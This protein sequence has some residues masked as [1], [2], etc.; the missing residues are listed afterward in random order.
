MYSI[1]IPLYNGVE[2]LKE[3]VNSVKEQTYQEW[4]II[5]GI[6]GHS[7]E[8]DVMKHALTFQN[9]KIRVKHYKTK[10]KP[11]TLNEMIKDTRYDNICILDVDD[12]WLPNKL[13]IQKDYID[14]YDVIGTHCKYFGD[15]DIVPPL[16]SGEIYKS[17][18]L[19]V[20]NI[21]NSSVVIKK[22]DSHWI[23][24]Q[25]LDD[26]ELWLRLVHDN[27]TFYNIPEIHVLHRIHKESAFNN[28]N[29]EY[30]KDLQNYWK[31]FSM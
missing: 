5:I 16:K 8:S 27:R 19:N 29:N 13:S 26:Y 28:S 10:G 17:D 15:S 12:I 7:E 1:L 6:N 22:K 4:E 14:S 20:N 9:E 3:S 30:V 31:I 21:V 2:Y 23:N 18:F 24:Q 25:G 11:N